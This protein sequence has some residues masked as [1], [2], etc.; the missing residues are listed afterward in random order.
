MVILKRLG[1]WTIAWIAGSG[2]PHTPAQFNANGT[3]RSSVITYL[4][5]K[6]VARIVQGLTPIEN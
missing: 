1:I 3:D 2:I 5:R 4:E 6:E